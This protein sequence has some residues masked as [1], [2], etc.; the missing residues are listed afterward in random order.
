MRDWAATRSCITGPA[1]V[2]HRVCP[3][4][5]A[6]T[7]TSLV[8][9]TADARRS[10]ESDLAYA[11]QRTVSFETVAR[12]ELERLGERLTTHTERTI[13]LARADADDDD[14]TTDLRDLAN[15]PP[16]VRY[17]NLLVRDAYDASASDIHLEAARTGLSA[18]FRVDRVLVPAP[19]AP[20]HLHHAVVSRIK[21]LAELDIAERRRP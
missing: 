19:E 16:V 15:H 3:P 21:L 9:A 20:T 8:A 2:H 6:R 13:E 5:S 1:D 14:L 10:S 17:V 18:R 11:Y 4:R 7:A 12:D